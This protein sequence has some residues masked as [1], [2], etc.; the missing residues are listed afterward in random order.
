MK[1]WSITSLVANY[2]TFWDKVEKEGPQILR[3]RGVDFIFASH[4]D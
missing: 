3:R 4:A 2:E 1:K